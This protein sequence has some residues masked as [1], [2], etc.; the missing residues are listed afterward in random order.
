M[1][2]QLYFWVRGL[3]FL[4]HETDLFDL[5]LIITIICISRFI[6]NQFTVF[7]CHPLGWQLNLQKHIFSFI[8]ALMKIPQL[9]IGH[10]EI[11]NGKDIIVKNA[12]YKNDSQVESGFPHKHN[13][14]M[15]CLIRN[16][17]GIHVVDFEEIPVVTNRLFILNPSQVH[18]WKLDTDANISLVQFA[19]S[20]FQFDNL[21]GGDFLSPASLF[22]KSYIDLNETQTSD[23]LNIFLKLEKEAN[24]KDFFSPEIIRGYLVVLSGIIGRAI[25][26]NN[27]SG[28]LNPKEQKLRE[29]MN[30]VNKHHTKQKGVNFYAGELNITANYLNMLSRQILGKNAGEVISLRVMLEAKRLL[31][32]TALDVS[33]IAFDLGFEDPSYFSRFFRK[34]E[35]NSPTEFREII[36]KKYQH[37]NN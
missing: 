27:Q 7:S 5:P 32:H 33:Q 14:Y 26:V 17:S 28:V 6:E 9:H 2:Q 34:T 8:L 25:N 10:T 36:Y 23:V 13:F 31:Y 37:P 12:V 16:G 4:H 19:E 15:I 1:E 18:F 22:R 30:L 21:P 35:N 20:V 29:F 11:A 24:E 3:Y